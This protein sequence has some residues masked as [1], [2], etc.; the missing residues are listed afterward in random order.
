MIFKNLFKNKKVLIT[1]H[2]GFK[3]S[4]LGLWLNIL[5]A[6]IIGVSKDIPT[7]PSHF[8]LKNNFYYKDLRFNLKNFSK[9]SNLI[10][11]EKPDFI[12]HLAAQPIVLK[13]YE[14]PYETYFSNS[15]GT[16]NILESLRLSNHPCSAVLITSD[17][18]YENLNKN[19]QYKE[20]DRLGGIDPYSS[21][22]ASA[23]LMIR[24]YCKAFFSKPNSK[25]RLASA[26]AGNV[27]GGGD[28]AVNRIVPDCMRSW[29]KNK[30]VTL[31]SPKSTRPWQHV[32]EPLCGYLTLTA[33]LNL[34][35]KLIGESFNF[36]PKANNSYSVEELVSKNYLLIWSM[37][38]M[39]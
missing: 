7:N 20:T 28:W 3:G 14:N 8:S 22:K 37:Q 26:R 2:T 10:G 12:F 36:G 19:I 6:K 39:L 11:V 13:S 34:N 32:L 18:C 1:G 25:V 21:S 29:S 24:S 17:K 27:M 4:W 23:E 30:K 35:K 38:N 16:L 31:R 33:K 9:I 15:V 5:G